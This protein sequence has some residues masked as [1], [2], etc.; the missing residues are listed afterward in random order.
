MI[1]PWAFALA[2]VLAFGTVS[3]AAGDNLLKNG[4]FKEGSQVWRGDGR[5]VFLKPDGTEG[6]ETDPGAKPA[7][8]VTL[9]PN[10]RRMVFQEFGRD[11]APTHLHVSVDVY[12]SVDFVRS[13][14]AEDY[15]SDDP[16]PMQM[17]DF[18]LRLLPEY[19][20]Q[21]ATLKTNDWTTVKYTVDSPQATSD[22]IIYFFIPPGHG[23]IYLRNAS[24]SP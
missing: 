24:V 23:V 1:S 16:M 9:S 8:R 14:H 2:V 11:I 18:S 19:A 7:L 3:S 10:S 22:R 12:S 15:Q 6:D 4:D 5:A 17:A 21:T 20:E 13:T